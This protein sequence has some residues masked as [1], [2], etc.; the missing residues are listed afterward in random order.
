MLEIFSMN[1][2]LQSNRTPDVIIN[3]IKKL[4]GDHQCYA[5]KEYR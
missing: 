5:Y 1:G 3:E 4:P 2:V